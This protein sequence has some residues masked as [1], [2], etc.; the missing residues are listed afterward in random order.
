MILFFLS[1]FFFFNTKKSIFLPFL[2]LF[3]ETKSTRLISLLVASILYCGVQN[4]R[5]YFVGH[6]FDFLMRIRLIY[7]YVCTDVIGHM[8]FE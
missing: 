3:L 7:V 6:V 8:Y 1:V 2:F 4:S 5:E